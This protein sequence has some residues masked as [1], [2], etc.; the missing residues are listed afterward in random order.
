MSSV[1]PRALRYAVFGNGGWSATPALPSFDDAVRY[2][3]RT[4]ATQEVAAT[5]K[6]AARLL[7]ALLRG[8]LRHSDP[9]IRAMAQ[10]TADLLVRHADLSRLGRPLTAVE[11]VEQSATAQQSYDGLMWLLARR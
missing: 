10:S 9:T 5:D 11:R 3:Q 8:C 1:R 2:Q 4:L 7:A 6:D